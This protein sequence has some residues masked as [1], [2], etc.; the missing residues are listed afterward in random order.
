MAVNLNVLRTGAEYM[1][2]FFRDRESVS[3]TYTRGATTFSVLANIGRTQAGP[4]QRT[5]LRLNMIEP[6]DFIISAAD[7]R[8][9]FADPEWV[10]LQGDTIVE[11]N[12]VLTCTYEVTQ[13][14]GKKNTWDWHSIY[15][16]AFRIHA[17]L[18]NTT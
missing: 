18:V 5:G 8:T 14:E 17:T 3:V 7:L 11:I 16:T 12:G 6:R 2:A 10:P 13:P 9:G 4:D 1:R 15:K